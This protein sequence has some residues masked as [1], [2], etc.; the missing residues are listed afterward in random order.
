MSEVPE[1]IDKPSSRICAV[2]V[3]TNSFHAVIVD[4][5]PDRSYRTIDNLKEM[6]NLG[7]DVVNHRLS[8]E[9]IH[10]AI[11]ALRKIKTLSDSNDVEHIVAYATSAIR[12]SENGGDFIQRAIDEI[13]IKIQAIPGIREAELIGYA[14]QHGMY[15]EEEPVL[16]MDIGGGSVE[17][18]IANRDTTFYLDSQKI[19]VSRTSSKF[20]QG[21]KITSEEIE[22]LRQHYTTC[23]KDLI[24]AEKRNP[25]KVLIGSSGTMQN[26]AFMMAAIK[27]KDVSLTLNEFE[28]STK[29]FKQFYKNFIK[30]DRAGRLKTAGMDEKRVDF[31]VTGLVLVDLIIDLFGI[32][33]IRTS[34]NALREGIIISYIKKEMKSIKRVSEFADPRRRSVFEL[35]R[36]CSWHEKHSV[37]VAKFALQLFDALQE[38]H[39]LNEDERELLEYASLMHDI[40]YHISHN[41]HHKHALYLILNAELKGFSQ[42]E[43]EIMAHVA[44]Y[45]RKSTPKKRH[46]LFWSL[47]DYQ[48]DRITKMAGILRV[49][50]GLDRSHYQNVKKLQVEYGDEITLKISSLD[51]PELEI[52]G[53]MRKRELFEEMFA[54]PLK[55]VRV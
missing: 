40:G 15:L 35:L 17:F 32:R 52:W 34:T 25:V 9:A 10:R 29:E 47:S 51:T 21:E 27:Q 54:R 8:D 16:A 41:R 12:E 1:K 53:A 11:D 48:K 46:Q 24:A 3:G 39:D 5:Y 20:M 30:L 7:P 2:D 38:Y 37:H 45:H 55:I 19:G 42:E 44:R 33:T 18:I 36:K 43:I 50:D 14:I 28:Y 23:L 49:A 4:V 31:I 13:G 6:V 22:Q 26:L